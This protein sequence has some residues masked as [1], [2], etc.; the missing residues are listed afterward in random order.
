MIVMGPHLKHSQLL[1]VRSRSKLLLDSWSGPAPGEGG[2]LPEPP[3]LRPDEAGAVQVVD[4]GR[5]L[6]RLAL[7]VGPTMNQQDTV[8]Q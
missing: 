1:G 2:Q 7:A 5:V 8:E 6:H 3:S 4:R